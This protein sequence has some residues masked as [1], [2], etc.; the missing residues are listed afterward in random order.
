MF[1]LCVFFWMVYLFFG[2]LVLEYYEFGDVEYVL[3]LVV[4]LVVEVLSIIGLGFS[5]VVNFCGF[6][7]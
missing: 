3:W 1:E 5:D 6:V 2:V 7:E 4:C